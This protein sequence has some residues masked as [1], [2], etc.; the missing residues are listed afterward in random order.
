MTPTSP[1]EA[2][3]AVVAATRADDLRPVLQSASRATGIA[4]EVERLA[5]GSLFRRLY[6]RRNR[7]TADLLLA[8]GPYLTQAAAL[9]GLLQPHQPSSWTSLPLPAAVT[10]AS[11]A[12]WQWLPLDFTPLCAA[13]EPAARS[14]G[15]L[16]APRA[17]RLAA[18]DPARSEAG[19]AMLLTTIDAFRQRS[20]GDPDAGWAWWQQ[21][22]TAGA[23]FFDESAPLLAAASSGQAT[24]AL[25]LAPSPLA[26]AD[27]SRLDDLPPLPNG[28]AL[29]KG[30]PHAAQAQT[31]LDWLAG[32]DG[33]GSLAATG[34]LSPWLASTNGLQ[35]HFDSAPPLDVAWAFAQYRAALAR[36]KPLLG[37]S[38]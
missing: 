25:L 24:H 22:V 18:L 36:W 32:R 13:G 11:A 8:F 7:P 31:V 10:T 4:I 37:F 30:S 16:A 6:E 20:G 29:V 1:P 33:A 14:M 3:V 26:S 34:F 9:E 38:A 27:S 23:L 5:T 19:A 17:A 2:V 12:G 28:V 21:R 15:E 35:V